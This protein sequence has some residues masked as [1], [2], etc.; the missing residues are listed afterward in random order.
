MI[1]GRDL[2]FA[3]EFFHLMYIYCR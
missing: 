3:T 1:F 2:K